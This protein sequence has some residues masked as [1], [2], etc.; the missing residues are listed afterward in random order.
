MRCMVKCTPIKDGSTILLTHDPLSSL[1]YPMITHTPPVAIN[2]S[3]KTLVARQWPANITVHHN[4][5]LWHKI[6]GDG[7]HY[8]SD[9]Y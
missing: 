3:M 6:N 1:A 2:F 7:V 4:C 5:G 8:D 9:V